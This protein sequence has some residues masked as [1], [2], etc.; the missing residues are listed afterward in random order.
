MQYR[1]EHLREDAYKDNRHIDIIPYLLY[2]SVMDVNPEL[3]KALDDS[4]AELAQLA[5]NTLQENDELTGSSTGGV[6]FRKLE[7][8]SIIISEGKRNKIYVEHFD[9]PFHRQDR[10][11]DEDQSFGVWPTSTEMEYDTDNGTYKITVCSGHKER[12][13]T[14]EAKLNIIQALIRAIGEEGTEVGEQD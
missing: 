6:S 1:I 12:P 7:L 5:K 14:P 4:A 13:L 10:E 11:D 8:G 9:A 3:Q 2:T